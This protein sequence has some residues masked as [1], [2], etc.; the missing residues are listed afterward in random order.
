MGGRPGEMRTASA[1]ARTNIAL[2]KYWGKR[3]RALNLPATGSL[4]LTLSS[5]RTTTRVTFD[6]TL[7]RDEMDLDGQEAPPAVAQR[8][9]RFLDLVRR[10]VGITMHA[11]V[12]SANNFPTASGL[13]SSA[14]GFAALALAATRAAGIEMDFPSLATLARLGSGSAPRSLLGGFVEMRPG[15]LP[16]GS[17]CLPVQV[18]PET[19]WDIAILVAV[20]GAATKEIGSTTAME[21]TRLTSPYYREWLRSVPGDIEVA[22]QAVLARDFSALGQVAESSCFRMHAVALGATPP[23]L[24][25]TGV[26]VDVV[27]KVWEFRRNGL[28]AYVTIDAGPH[29]KVLARPQ[30]AEELLRGIAAVPG[31]TRVLVERPGPGARITDGRAGQ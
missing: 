6:E 9:G 16:D 7:D 26:T 22:R 10:K 1:D 2:V 24:F 5:L 31:V 14:S 4:S 19:H 30:D 29:V 12:E 15:A 20:N 8:T 13:A 23:L 21:L 18:A 28:E 3:D 27:R 25:W 17:D 11:R